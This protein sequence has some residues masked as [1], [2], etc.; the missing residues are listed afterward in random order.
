MT[1]TPS[2]LIPGLNREST[3]EESELSHLALMGLEDI[4]SWSERKRMAAKHHVEIR[5]AG[6]RAGIEWAARE[7][8]LEFLGAHEARGASRFL[9]DRLAAHDAMVEVM[10]LQ[11]AG[12]GAMTERELYDIETRAIGRHIRSHQSGSP[13]C[14]KADFEEC[15]APSCAAFNALIRSLRAAQK[16]GKRCPQN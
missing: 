9:L 13:C 16:R 8:N 14:Y 7:I 10:D 11:R 4:K 12:G 15:S 2:A 1:A 6:V 3:N 5:A